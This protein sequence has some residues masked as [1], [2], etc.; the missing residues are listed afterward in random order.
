MTFRDQ[1]KTDFLKHHK[2]PIHRAPQ[3]QTHGEVWYKKTDGL[4]LQPETAW[5]QSANTALQS[6]A[7]QATVGLTPFSEKER[8]TSQERL[9]SHQHWTQFVSILHVALEPVLLF[10]KDFTAPPHFVMLFIISHGVPHESRPMRRSSC[11]FDQWESHNAWPAR[12]H[13]RFSTLSFPTNNKDQTS[14]MGS[15]AP[16]AFPQGTLFWIYVITQ[17]VWDR[18]VML[19]INCPLL[20]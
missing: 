20:F 9:T 11:M 1:K 10:P 15:P 14:A 5:K 12:W 7:V 13:K 17:V 6:T 3:A 2:A 4:R 8:Q 18:L 16:F 19:E